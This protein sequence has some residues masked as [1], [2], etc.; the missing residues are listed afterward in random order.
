MLRWLLVRI[1]WAWFAARDK[2]KANPAEQHCTEDIEDDAYR[3][4][5]G[6]LADIDSDLWRAAGQ[7][8]ASIEQRDDNIH[9]ERKADG[10]SNPAARVHKTT[11]SAR[12]QLATPNVWVHPRAEAGEACC[13]TSGATKG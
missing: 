6:A 13:S 9:P 11:E 2:A 8:D 5:D 10:R 1:T 7:V 4:R 12:S 3:I